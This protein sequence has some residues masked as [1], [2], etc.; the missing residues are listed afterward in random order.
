MFGKFQLAKLN[1]LFGSNWA[2][3]CDFV[4]LEV[5]DCSSGILELLL[6]LLTLF[7]SDILIIPMI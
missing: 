5:S 1:V 2:M 7:G 4:T 3:A 6:S